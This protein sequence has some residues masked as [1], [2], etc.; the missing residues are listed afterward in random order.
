[1]KERQLQIYWVPNAISMDIPSSH[2]SY[3]SC[4]LSML[5]WTKVCT[6]TGEGHIELHVKVTASAGISFFIILTFPCSAYTGCVGIAR[7][8]L[9]GH[10]T[11]LLWQIPRGHLHGLSH[12]QDNTW[13]DLWWTSR[14]H[15]WGQVDS[16]LVEFHLSE[17]NGSYWARTWKAFLTETL[18][19]IFPRPSWTGGCSVFS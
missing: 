11:L 14:K 16:M 19:V 9:M 7:S 17:T 4:I 2:W 13:R 5:L 15:W 1:M 8:L 10:N 3:E 12:R 6:P 18:T